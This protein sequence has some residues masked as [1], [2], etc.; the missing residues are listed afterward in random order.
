MHLFPENTW[1]VEVLNLPHV[2]PAR[3]RPQHPQHSHVV[4]RSNC[5]T[6]MTSL[7]TTQYCVHTVSHTARRLH[8]PHVVQ[9]VVHVYHYIHNI[10]RHR[11]PSHQ[12]LR[13]NTHPHQGINMQHLAS[14]SQSIC[15]N[16]LFVQ[17]LGLG[18]P[19]PPH[20]LRTDA[21]STV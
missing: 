12:R 11:C 16:E 6:R 5:N 13:S 7:T 9:H 3:R 21:T 4:A 19:I 15:N 20:H 8:T 14:T 10:F 2:A 17:W 18:A 1:L